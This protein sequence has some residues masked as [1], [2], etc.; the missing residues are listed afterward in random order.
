MKFSF[1]LRMI[2]VEIKDQ[3]HKKLYPILCNIINAYIFGKSLF[4]SVSEIFR[5]KYLV[6]NIEH[7]P[8]QLFSNNIRTI[9]KVYEQ[10]YTKNI[11]LEFY[12][13]FEYDLL[14]KDI[15]S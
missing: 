15:Q 14:K 8:S 3:I 2:K 7:E 6:Y 12:K 9:K 13:A 4:T 10:L 5:K 11:S 1:D